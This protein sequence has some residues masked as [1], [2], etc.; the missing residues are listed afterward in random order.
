MHRLFSSNR[1]IN[2]SNLD[3]SWVWEGVGECA[4]AQTL[5]NLIFFCC[6]ELNRIYTLLFFTHPLATF[7]QLFFLVRLVNISVVFLFPS[8]SLLYQGSA[9]VYR[10][11]QG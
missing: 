9:I 7:C 8:L 10:L 4:V 11:R 5:K 2:V 1:S 3:D 6:N